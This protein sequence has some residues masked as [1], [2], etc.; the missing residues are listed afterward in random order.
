MAGFYTN[1]ALVGGQVYYRGYRENGARDY[2]RK[3]LRPYL[4]V[5]V[6]DPGV[7][8]S[9]S[10]YK[11]L[12]GRSV[13]RMD[14]ET[15]REARGWIEQYEHVRGMHL[16]GME[17][18]LYPF[19]YDAFREGVSYDY[20]LVRVK[21]VDIETASDGGFPNIKEGN[22][23]ITAITIEDLRTGRV[24]AFG[25]GKFSVE[26]VN[27]HECADE[28]ELL[29]LFL[30]AWVGDYPDIVTGWNIDGFDVPY[31]IARIT[32]VLG[33]KY[34]AKL[35]PWGKLEDR[36]AFFMGAEQ[37]V[38]GILGVTS[39]DYMRLIRNK[40]LSIKPRESYSLNF[41][42]HEEL[43]EKKIDYSEYAGLQDLYLRDFQ[44]FM[45]YNVHDVR[46]VVKLER[47]L[48]FIELV[49]S[50]AYAARVNYEDVLGSVRQ[51]DVII[52]NR[53]MDRGIVVPHS[54]PADK[55][56]LVGAY[57]KE[58][59]TGFY[60]WVASIDL[61]SLY[62]HLQM[63][64]NVSPETF[65]CKL[66]DMTE[67]RIDQLMDGLSG[68]TQHLVDRNVTMAGNLCCYTKEKRGIVP[69]ILEELYN[70]RV[71]SKKK[72]I[73]AKKRKEAEKDP[74]RKKELEAE[75]ARHFNAQMAAKINLNSAYGVLTN[76]YFRFYN[77]DNAEAITLSGQLA[78]RWAE[79]KVNAFLNQEMGTEGVDYVIAADTDSL[80]VNLGPMVKKFMPNNSKA[81]VL[82]SIDAY[83]GD[84]L[85]GAIEEGYQEL[86]RLTNSMGQKMKMKRESIADRAYSLGKKRYILNILDK[87]GVTFAVP[88]VE[89][90]GMEAVRS[91]TP[92]S[93]RAKIKEVIRVI[94][95]GTQADLIKF[96]KDYR[97]EFEGLPFEEVAFPRSISGL[98]KYADR[99]LTYKKG[100][101]IQ[102]RGALI[103]NRL[104]RELKLNMNP[105][106]DGDK[107][108]F[109]YLREPNTAV[110]NVIA[111]PMGLPPEFNLAD[112]IDRDLQFEKGF[113]DP[114]SKIAELIG[115]R[116]EESR[117]IDDLFE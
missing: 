34:A 111:V 61:N 115:W 113:F 45:E 105:I 73:D 96:V 80:Y 43:G 57:V 69:E 35:S 92:S 7:D 70:S 89:I 84:R 53:L 44:K 23:A 85:E 3:T 64:F 86:A 36:T 19:I 25:C 46:L 99:S 40:K 62:S 28:E 33:E 106:Y 93:C 104:V 67:S 75:E 68:Y 117:T 48:R 37:E 102:V 5:R 78:I 97:A 54:Q 72:M 39:L 88:E 74:A 103:Y 65:V 13:Q 55:D 71:E 101:P 9:N 100:T 12:Q 11:D 18:F 2:W 114:V 110:D 79:R 51:W 24:D 42:A 58:S 20:D 22:K 30:Q 77:H 116:M 59:L 107:V 52:H 95:N 94:V 41:I 47:K 4:F 16:Y 63:Q 32:R 38:K 29:A 91:S 26:G 31:L 10:P 82:R 27:C 50:M 66:G 98:R 90:K 21:C 49:V 83:V 112:K 76:A 56:F 60:E 17:K 15:A 8:I 81:L 1:V 109:V 6:D 108:K 87:E 14:F